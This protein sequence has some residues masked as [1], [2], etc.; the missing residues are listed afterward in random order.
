MKRVFM[1]LFV[2]GSGIVVPAGCSTAPDTGGD[3]EAQQTMAET[4]S[5]DTMSG[6]EG[7]SSAPA[8]SP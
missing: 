6:T 3:E 4:I 7:Q 5:A 1:L 2:I 8:A